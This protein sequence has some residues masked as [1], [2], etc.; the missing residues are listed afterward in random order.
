M[1]FR[2]VRA[3]LP[4]SSL[5]NVESSTGNFDKFVQICCREEEIE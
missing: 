5:K 4:S 1:F 2:C 3:E